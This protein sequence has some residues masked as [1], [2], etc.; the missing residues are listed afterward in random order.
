MKSFHVVLIFLSTF[1]TIQTSEGVHI[2]GAYCGPDWCGS[3]IVPECSN[4]S[5]GSSCHKK[6]T[7]CQE[8]SPNDGSCADSCCQSHDACCGSTDRRPCNNNIIQCLKNCKRQSNASGC[9]HNNIDVPVEVILVAMELDPYGCCGTS[10]N[11]NEMTTVAKSVAPEHFLLDFATDIDGVGV[12][13]LNITRAWSPIGVDHLFK[14][15]ND[16][17]YDESAFTRVDGGFVLQFG[18]SGIPANNVKY[19]QSIK[20]DPVVQSNIQFTMSYAATSEKNSRT[21]QLFINYQ[22]N[23]ELDG[24]GFSP[25][26]I[27]VKGN[28]YLN[29]VHDPTPGDSNGVDQQDYARKGNAWIRQKYPEINFI[30][31]ATI[32]AGR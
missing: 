6:S 19:N 21:T 16:G 3:R 14:L 22:N 28:E 12:I 31:K 18:I 23:A 25:V 8:L 2:C 26:G 15:V 29:R 17:F 5:A 9:R 27:V 7:D 10:C 20:D 30:K 11:G 4:Y 24:Q 32:R 1:Q 13:T